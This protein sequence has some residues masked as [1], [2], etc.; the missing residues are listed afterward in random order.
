MTAVH[1]TAVRAR[2]FAAS[3]PAIG[4]SAPAIEGDDEVDRT[5]PAVT[6]TLRVTLLGEEAPAAAAQFVTALRSVSEGAVADSTI[7]ISSPDRNRGVSRWSELDRR[8]TV[9]PQAGAELQIFVDQ[10]V[11]SLG[12]NLVP[13]SRREYD[14]LLFLAQH[15]RRVFTRAQLLQSVWEYDFPSGGRTVDVHVR[16]LRVKLDGRGPTIATVRGV[17]YR[18]DEPER[19][20]VVAG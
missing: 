2:R 14:L 1:P 9:V 13:L 7:T 4:G 3:A 10:R 17:G 16:R 15:P 11:V 19:V 6:V 12:N 5:A 20:R 8:L 18:L